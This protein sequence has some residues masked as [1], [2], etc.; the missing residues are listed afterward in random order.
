MI[1]FF[2]SNGAIGGR[3]PRLDQGGGMPVKEKSVKEL[4]SMLYDMNQSALEGVYLL[5]NALIYNSS[6]SLEE[7]E[8]KIKAIIEGEK[9]LT[10]AFAEKTKGTG[11][12]AYALVPGHIE[13]IGHFIENI[14]RCTRVKIG[15]GISFSDRAVS[16]IT[17]LME[18]L[19]EVLQNV[20]DIILARNAIIRDYIK[21]SV[22][23]IGRSADG[24]E[25][26][27]GEKL[28]EGLCTPDAAALFLDIL[29]AI[30]VISWHAKEIAESL[31]ESYKPA[32]A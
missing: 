8:D 21:E 20:G 5:R 26:S 18:R 15:G 7:C 30:K 25:T 12:R 2:C 16:E 31:T 3:D 14:I 19:Q 32:A 10:P 11:L 4:V 22:A 6:K 1:F 28:I 27:H 23:E 24:F 9:I 13:R 29:D 17:F